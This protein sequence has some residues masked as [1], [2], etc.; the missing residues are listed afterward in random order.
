M[1]RITLHARV[2]ASSNIDLNAGAMMLL[3]ESCI[4]SIGF[5]G[6]KKYRP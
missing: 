5:F 1:L 3:D 2:T 6:K 4:I